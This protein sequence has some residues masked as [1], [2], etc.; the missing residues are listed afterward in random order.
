[1]AKQAHPVSPEA[2]ALKVTWVV[3]D[4]KV[5]KDFKAREA[6]QVNP[7][8]PV[9]QGPL[10]LLERTDWR[11]TKVVRVRLVSLERLA[12]Q[13]PE[14]HQVLLEAPVLLVLKDIPVSLAALV[15]RASKVSREKAVLLD[16][17]VY[18]VRQVQLANVERSV[19]EVQVELL[20]H[21]EKEAHLAVEVFLELM[22]HQGRKVKPVIEDLLDPTDQKAKLVTLAVLAPRVYKDFV[23][24]QAV[25]VLLANLVALVNVVCPELMVK[26]ANK[27]LRVFKV[28]LDL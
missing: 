14:V 19:P 2:P 26:M 10:D 24:F 5:A 1:M 12:S 20:A 22:D 15:L 11:E 6:K 16:L 23:V 17:A 9:K 27:V 21:L 28:C 8:C 18:Q 13:E 25:Q 3:L 7:V 4:Q